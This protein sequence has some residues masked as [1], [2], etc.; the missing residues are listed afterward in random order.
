[1]RC[2]RPLLILLALFGL[3]GTVV[4]EP[5][6]PSAVGRWITIDDSSHKKKSIVRIWERDR[7]LYGN[8][9]E[10]FTEPGEDP[11]PICNKCEGS[12]RDRPVKGMMILWQMRKDDDEWSGGR[13]L[14]PENGKVYRCTIK[15]AGGGQKLK[16]RGY[17]GVSLFGRTQVWE[18]APEPGPP[19]T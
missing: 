6:A 5:A 10:L 11:N 9:E 7:M 4:A 15:L 14:D 19:G 1:M 2:I 8:I 13:I 12:L 16:V 18:R 3:R 17:V